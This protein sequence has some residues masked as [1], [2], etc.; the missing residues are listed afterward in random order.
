MIQKVDAVYPFLSTGSKYNNFELRY[1]LRSLVRN[2]AGLRNVYIA[3]DRLP[4]FITGVELLVVTDEPLKAAINMIKKLIAACEN[5]N[6]SDPFLAINDDHFIMKPIDLP[7][8][9]FHHRGKLTPRN[10]RSNYNKVLTNTLQVCVEH[11]LPQLNYDAHTPMLIYKDKFLAAMAKVDWQGLTSPGV[12]P[13]SY[14]GNTI[15][16]GI[17][18]EDA[19]NIAIS[20]PPSSWTF[21]ST[22]TTMGSATMAYLRETFP[23]S[24]RFENPNFPEAID[25]VVA[26]PKKIHTPKTHY[27]NVVR[28]NPVVTGKKPFVIYA[29]F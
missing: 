7:T 24:C 26:K 22:Y 3:S 5:V 25:T 8:L 4:D 2:G 19:K 13:K 12:L 6:I 21:W 27:P 11:N 23:T 10:D 28:G 15:G 9:S 18:I 17:R 16:G 29:N 1:S 20:V 14:Y